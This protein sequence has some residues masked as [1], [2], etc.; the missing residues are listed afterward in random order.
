[1]VSVGI[2]GASGYT[3]AELLRLIAQHPDLHLVCATGESQAGGPVEHQPQRAVVT[4]F[5][6]EHH[7]A[8]EVR[9]HQGR[10]GQQQ[11]PLQHRGAHDSIMPA[12]PTPYSRDQHAAAR[13]RMIM[14]M[15]V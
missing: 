1:M 5:Q 13:D 4:V 3:G 12:A 11:L 8:V 9:I 15:C 10:G 6:D 2:I 14:H 7:R